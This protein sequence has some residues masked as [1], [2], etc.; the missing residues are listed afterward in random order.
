MIITLNT[1]SDLISLLANKSSG[2]ERQ[3]IVTE[4]FKNK[5]DKIVF[6]ANELNQK[7]KTNPNIEVKYS[8]GRREKRLEI[9]YNSKEA[10]HICKITNMVEFDKD[11]I[12]LEMIIKDTIIKKLIDVNRICGVLIFM[13]DYNIDVVSEF[14]SNSNMMISH[15]DTFNIIE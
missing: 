2:T 3:Y 15:F 7:L 8:F 4:V 1:K 13:G 5:L 12:E 14:L 10:L 6:V 11:A 9:V